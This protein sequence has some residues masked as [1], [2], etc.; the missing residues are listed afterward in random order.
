MIPRQTL[1]VDQIDLSDLEFWARPLD[2]REGAFLTLRQERPLPFFK[3]P[4]MDVAGI[5]VGPGY[6]AVTKHADILEI[7]RQPELF[8]SGQGSTSITDMPDFMSEFSAR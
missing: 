4:E 6:Y 2:E 8:C 1:T 5:T 3:E 7:S